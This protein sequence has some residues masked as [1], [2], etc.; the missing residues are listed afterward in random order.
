MRADGHP[1]VGCL[2]A[3]LMIDGDRLRVVEFN[4]RFGD[5]ETQV[6]LPLID[7]DLALILHAAATGRLGEIGDLRSSGTAVCIVIAS[8][9]YPGSYRKGEEIRGIEE[10]EKLEGVV[11]F[12]AGTKLDGDRL[13]TSGGRV[14]GVTAISNGDDLEKTIEQAYRGV[15]QVSFD[16]G[17]YRHDIGRKGVRSN[18]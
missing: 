7:G 4:S 5:P 6:V 3:G 13:V 15:E 17:F 12:H 11:V 9:G 10:A 2:Y 16:G 18:V 1:Y 14:L 8:E